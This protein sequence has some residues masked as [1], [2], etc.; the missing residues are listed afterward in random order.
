MKKYRFIIFAL[1]AVLVLSAGLLTAC[2]KKNFTVSLYE[3]GELV[4]SEE[5]RQGA[6][7]FAIHQTPPIRGVF[8]NIIC[9]NTPT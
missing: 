2:N 5:F 7:P 4:W 9:V 6:F 1:V 8:F 3:D